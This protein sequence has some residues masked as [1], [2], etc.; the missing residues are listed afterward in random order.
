VPRQSLRERQRLAVRQEIQQVSLELFLRRGF[1]NVA[2]AEIAEAAG[3]SDR[4]FYRHFATK[5]D[6]VLVLFDGYAPG[7]HGHLRDHEGEGRPWKVL[8]DAFVIS[9][10]SRRAVT[11]E[12][13][14]MV[15]ETPRLLTAYFERQRTWEAMVAEVIAERLGVDPMVDPRPSLW[16]MIAF[17]I[18]YRVSYEN[19]MVDPR[20]DLIANLEDRYRQAELLFTGHLD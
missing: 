2:V 17:G 1:D 6:V 8:C 18:A 11:P 12:V 13:L 16:A 7:I 9:A 4:T 3:V 10:S 14:R 15:I 19:V 20:D 5:E